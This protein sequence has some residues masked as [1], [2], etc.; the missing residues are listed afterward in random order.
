MKTSLL[1][2]AGPVRDWVKTADGELVLID[3]L[4]HR[5]L[6]QNAD[7]RLRVAAT[8]FRYPRSIAVLD[9]MA[10]VVDSWN[11]RVRAFHLPEWNSAFEFGSFFCPSWIAIMNDLLVVADTNN[12]RL[13][14]HEP[15]GSP[16]F[17]YALDGCPKRVGANSNGDIVVH[18]DNGETETLT[19]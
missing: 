1:R 9:S 5:V 7:G 12:R 18:Y 16:L 17:T 4:N 19:Y 2:S 8:G 15:N 13:S 3:E 14:F 6:M 10:Y 11:H